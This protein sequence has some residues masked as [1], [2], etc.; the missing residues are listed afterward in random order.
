M[1]TCRKGRFRA[2]ACPRARASSV[3]PTPGGPK[4]ARMRRSLEFRALASSI[5][6]SSLARFMPKMVVSRWACTRERILP[7]CLS[8]ASPGFCLCSRVQ[9][10]WKEVTGM[11]RASSMNSDSLRASASSRGN[12]SIAWHLNSS[13][14]CASSEKAEFRFAGAAARPDRRA[15]DRPARAER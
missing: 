9:S 3:L 15:A 5:M 14:F 13:V 4:K 11:R 10:F 7:S 8:R 1:D 2:S 12:C 6:I